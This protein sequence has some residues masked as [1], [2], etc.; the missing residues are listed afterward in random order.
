MESQDQSNDIS[1]NTSAF[2]LI[3]HELQ[4]DKISFQ[5]STKFSLSLDVKLDL[6]FSDSTYFAH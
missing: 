4:D 2:E 5:A 3:R 1:L 6:F